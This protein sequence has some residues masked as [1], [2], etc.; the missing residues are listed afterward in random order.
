MKWIGVGIDVPFPIMQH[1]VIVYKR[2]VTEKKRKSDG[3]ERVNI[4][5]ARK[6]VID[7]GERETKWRKVGSKYKE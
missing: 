7:V 3:H 6:I 4:S 1:I 2:T 5:A